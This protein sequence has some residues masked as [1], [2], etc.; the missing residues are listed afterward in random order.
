MKATVGLKECLDVTYLIPCKCKVACRMHGMQAYAAH[1][2][3]DPFSDFPGVHNSSSSFLVLPRSSGLW[4]VSTTLESTAGVMRMH[5]HGG[6]GRN[7]KA[8]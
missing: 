3:Q 1:S 6:Y 7:L 2:S 8:R 5:G 4:I